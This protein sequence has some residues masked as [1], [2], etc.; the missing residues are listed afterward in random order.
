VHLRD[1]RSFGA[2]CR[3]R[4]QIVPEA[5]TKFHCR[6]VL[7][8]VVSAGSVGE[9]GSVNDVVALEDRARLV[10]ADPHG[11]ALLNAKPAEVAHTAP[12]QI[13][14]QQARNA[15]AGANPVPDFRN[16]FTS[17]PFTKVPS[18][19]FLS[20]RVNTKSSGCLPMRHAVSRVATTRVIL[21]VRPSPFL[22]VAGGRNTAG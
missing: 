16:P 11:H 6:S 14:K 3:N 1:C 2:I 19:R 17:L 20:G 15:R 22:V 8:R 10:T 4:A 9:V 13:V 7:V 18:L 5:L 21:I 12:S